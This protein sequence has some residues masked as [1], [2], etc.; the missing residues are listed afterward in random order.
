M[1]KELTP[2]LQSF[3]QKEEKEGTLPIYFMKLILPWYQDQSKT[4]QKK[5]ENYRATFL[6]NIEANI[7]N[8]MLANTI[9]QYIKRIIFQE[10]KV[11]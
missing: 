1:F 7:L 4:E 10:C 6:M 3:I 11:G 2:I 9:Q 8:K 5:R